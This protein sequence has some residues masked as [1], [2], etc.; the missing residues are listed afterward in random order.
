MGADKQVSFEVQSLTGYGIS[1]DG[2]VAE[3]V[4]F[5]MRAH[6]SLKPGRYL[7]IDYV[8]SI[9]QILFSNYNVFSR[10]HESKLKLMR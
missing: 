9:F 3:F 4:I 5:Q 2:H 6:G 10:L 1:Y 8:F 7:T